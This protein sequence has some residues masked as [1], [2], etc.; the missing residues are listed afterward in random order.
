MRERSG[1]RQRTRPRVGPEV[2]REGSSR[3]SSR[4]QRT[5]CRAEPLSR[6][7]A[8]TDAIAATISASG[9]SATRSSSS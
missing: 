4:N 3:P 2:A 6:K 9:S 7:A 5:V 8:K 1:V